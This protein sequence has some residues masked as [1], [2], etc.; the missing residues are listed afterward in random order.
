MAVEALDIAESAGGF[1]VQ[2]FVVDVPDAPAELEG[3]PVHT[4]DTLPEFP[5]SCRLV[6]AIIS[7]RRRAFVEAMAARGCRF[8]TVAHP[9]AQIS[10]R[11]SVGEGCLIHPGTIV[12]SNT[13]IGGHV[14]VNRGAL[15]GH[16][17]RIGAFTTVG[18]GANLAGALCVGEGV[19]IGVGAVIRDHLRIGAGAV[20]AA[21]AVVVNNVEANTLVGGLPARVLKTGVKGL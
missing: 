18:P 19:Y 1:A 15:I 12:A 16:D 21:G 14:V 11:A 17:N 10:R 2:G 8:A 20:V 3:Y 7:T 4:L 5:A 13:S 6:A 9:T